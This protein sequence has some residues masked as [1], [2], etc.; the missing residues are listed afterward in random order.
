MQTPIKFYGDPVVPSE[1]SGIYVAGKICAVPLLKIQPMSTA[2]VRI[3]PQEGFVIAADGRT[4]NDD[5][6]IFSDTAQKI[7]PVEEDA[8]S[9]AYAM[10]GVTHIP[11][12]GGKMPFD[13]HTEAQEVIKQH[14]KRRPADLHRYAEIVCR[15]INSNL[16]D[17]KETGRIREYPNARDNPERVLERR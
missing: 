15:G 9:L 11:G 1:W 13:L 14:V 16:R 5:Y 17:A 8:R 4:Q 6:T 3:Y 12:Q 2:I 10:A 7:F